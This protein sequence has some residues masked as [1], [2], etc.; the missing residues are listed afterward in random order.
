MSNDKPTL[1][2]QLDRQAGAIVTRLRNK[3]AKSGYYENLG[4][5]ELRAFSDKVNA[6]GLDFQTRYQLETMLSNAI[7]S[8]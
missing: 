6:S 5:Q 1:Y 3:V 7:D 4:Q 8:I 2:R